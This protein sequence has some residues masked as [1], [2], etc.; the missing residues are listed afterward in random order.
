MPNVNG[1]LQSLADVHGNTFVCA[2]AATKTVSSLVVEL[3]FSQ[4]ESRSQTR[5]TDQVQH[6]LILVI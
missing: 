6:H 1:T 3:C 2:S 4:E 5:V